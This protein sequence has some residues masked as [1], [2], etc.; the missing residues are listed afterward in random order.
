MPLAI[1]FSGNKGMQEVC[2]V[3]LWVWIVV[4]K[5]ILKELSKRTCQSLEL[6]YDPLCNSNKN[7][8]KPTKQN[9]M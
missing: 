2:K 5:T 1:Y 4:Y 3:I 6:A 9:A 8:F 7:T